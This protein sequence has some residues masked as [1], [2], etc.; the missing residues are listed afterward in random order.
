MQNMNDDAQILVVCFTNHAL[1]SFIE[2]I[3][4]YTNNVVRIGG[5]CKNEKVAEYILDN[6]TK[7]STG[8]YKET[9]RKIDS[10]G[11]N[12]ENITSL[13]NSRRR[14]SLGDVKKYFEPLFNKV[15]NDFFEIMNEI[16]KNEIKDDIKYNYNQ[17]KIHKE[18]YI[19]WNLID[20]H[21]EKNRPDD[22]IYKL[23][24]CINI[25]DGK[26]LDILYQKILDNFIGYDLDNLELLRKIKN[27]E[28]VETQK[29]EKLEINNQNNPNE[30]EEEEEDDEEEEL[31]Q[32][33]E[34][35]GY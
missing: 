2:D 7:Y 15:I 20:N 12:M 4:K 18:I 16:I 13:F 9:V 3:I 22:I 32:N 1:D 21:N 29:K 25:N 6:K 31:A 10:I 27:S 8:I 17:D 23:L 19:F 14:V 33:L 28:N 5:R 11:E 35:I 34:R 24:N 30:E 26:K